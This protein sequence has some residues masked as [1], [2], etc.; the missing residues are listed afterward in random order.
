MSKFVLVAQESHTLPYAIKVDSESFESAVATIPE[1][2]EG[3]LVFDPQ[4]LI[5]V[6][7]GEV[8]RLFKEGPDS[9][10]LSDTAFEKL[11]FAT[12]DEYF[13]AGT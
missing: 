8:R 9:W 11:G 6:E 7:S 2:L 3:R 10:S 13:E 12:P 5:D 1:M 4:L